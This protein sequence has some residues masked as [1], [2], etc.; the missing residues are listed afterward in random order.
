MGYEFNDS[1]LCMCDRC[2]EAYPVD[3]MYQLK[4]GHIIC[5]DCYSEGWEDDNEN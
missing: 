4:D 2:G 1:E 5:E 3:E